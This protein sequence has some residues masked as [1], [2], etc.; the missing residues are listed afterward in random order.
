MLPM[1]LEKREGYAANPE[2]E[3]ELCPYNHTCARGAA[4]RQKQLCANW[5]LTSSES[6][7]MQSHTS[8]LLEAGG[9][10]LRCVRAAP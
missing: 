1:D 9:E 7:L 8:A 3:W 2:N 10:V 6:K 5:R 4:D